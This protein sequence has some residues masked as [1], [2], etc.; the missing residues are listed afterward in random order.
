VMN[1]N[2]AYKLFI[3]GHTDSQGDNAMNLDLSKRR[4]AAVR[5]YLISKGIAGERMRTQG[6]GETRPVADNGTAAGRAKN[7]RVEFKVEF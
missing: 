7:R 2:P 4:A 6:F 5:Q 1:D 3:Q